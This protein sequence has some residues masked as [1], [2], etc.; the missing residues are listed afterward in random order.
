MWKNKNKDQ[1][2]AHQIG[3]YMHVD[4]HSQKK[5]TG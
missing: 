3:N 2:E 5:H 1:Q 4:T